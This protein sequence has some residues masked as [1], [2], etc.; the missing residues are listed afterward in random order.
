MPAWL[1]ALVMVASS[2]AIATCPR[3]LADQ[4]ADALGLQIADLP[5]RI[6]PMKVS[7]MHRN[8]PDDGVTWLVS[9]LQVLAA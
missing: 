5:N 7:A 1:T 2:D 3:R 9:E 8:Q 6:A 4:H